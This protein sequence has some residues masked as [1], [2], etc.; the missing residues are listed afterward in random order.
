MSSYWASFPYNYME[1]ER[2]EYQVKLQLKGTVVITL[3]DSPFKD[4]IVRFT[5]I[6]FDKQQHF[7]NQLDF[8]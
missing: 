1:S 3:N 7:L 6:S 2:K 4:G 5:I 8:S